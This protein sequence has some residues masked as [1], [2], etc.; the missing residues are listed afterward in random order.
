MMLTDLLPEVIA[1]WTAEETTPLNTANDMYAYM[2]GGAELYLSYGFRQALSRK[3]RKSGK[4][5]VTAEVYDLIE[6]RNAYGVFS[7]TR[8]TENLHM[9]Q[10]AFC[11][12]GAVFFWKD[13]YYISLSTWESTPETE[14]FIR[15]LGTFIDTKI[16][17]TAEVPA[18]VKL[19]PEEGLVP[20][21]YLYFHHYIWL[22]AYVY[23]ADNNLLCIDDS[24]DAVMAKYGNPEN[25]MYLLII[26]Y[27]GQ[28][29][30]REAFASFGQRFF[31]GG[32]TGNCTRLEDGAWLAASTYDRLIAAVFNGINEQPTHQLLM[33]AIDQYKALNLKQNSK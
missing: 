27:S 19:L 7:H 3:Y 29:A 23:I 4:P 20:F 11:L 9:G 24:T 14:E 17:A 10:G 32:L 25:R 6:A 21:G 13:H 31:P 33:N 28:D 12:T 1:E 18:V 16:P 30:A 26:Q 2:D 8:E 5:E 22:N 15:I